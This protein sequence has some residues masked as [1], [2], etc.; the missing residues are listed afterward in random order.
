MSLGLLVYSGVVIGENI[1]QKD[2]AFQ[3]IL[4]KN[5][6]HFTDMS[7]PEKN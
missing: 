4:A 6:L 7:F 5:T 1:G 3:Q 2:I